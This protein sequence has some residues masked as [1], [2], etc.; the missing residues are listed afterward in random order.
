MINSVLILTS[1]RFAKVLLEIIFSIAMIAKFSPLIYAKFAFLMLLVNLL[2]MV[3][4]FGNSTFIY[5]ILTKNE[6]GE[7][8]YFGSLRNMQLALLPISAIALWFL[9][10]NIYLGILVLATGTLPSI[11]VMSSFYNYKDLNGFYSAREF[12]TTA[13][14]FVVKIAFIYFNADVNFVIALSL[15]ERLTLIL[16]LQ[17]STKFRDGGR[18][19]LNLQ[20]HFSGAF[21]YFLVALTGLLYAQIDSWMVKYF[22]GEAKFGEF[23]AGLRLAEI[24]FSIIPTISFVFLPRMLKAGNEESKNIKLAI[25]VVR[26]SIILFFIVAPVGAVVLANTPILFSKYPGLSILY[27]GLLLSYFP[28]VLIMPFAFY[29]VEQNLQYEK[30]IIIVIGLT[31]N[32]TID[33][34]LIGSFGYYGCIVGTAIAQSAVATIVAFRYPFIR[35][36]IRHSLSINR[37]K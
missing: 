18:I 17:I 14:F 13:T 20:E 5:K 15:I 32:L 24:G 33:Y 11:Q 21:P 19:N 4:T 35:I 1:A 23:S 37:E 6:D 16:I 3:W 36:A 30:F 31:I 7:R 8:S 34:L 27:A 9:N 29:F 28:T 12:T 22:L 26:V 10:V 2:G 25:N